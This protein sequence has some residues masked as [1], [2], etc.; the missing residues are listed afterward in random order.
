MLAD[1]IKMDLEE[2]G[3]GAMDWNGLA[4]D[5]NKWRAL[6][7]VVMNLQF[8]KVLGSSWVAAFNGLWSSEFAESSRVNSVTDMII[9]RFVIIKYCYFRL[10]ARL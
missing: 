4:Q 2:V 8:H 10:P 3:W 1:N 7:K 9:N 5:G 6:V